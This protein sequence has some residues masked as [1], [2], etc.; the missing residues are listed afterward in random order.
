MKTKK[1]IKY[2]FFPSD[3]SKVIAELG[4]DV[5]VEQLKR[6][7]L[8]RNFEM[9]AEAAYLQ[10]KI[11]GFFH[12]YIG[13][14]A[15]QTSAVCAMSKEQ[16]WVTTYRCHALALLLDA[17]PNELLAELFG[18]ATGNAKGRGGSMHF[19]TERL[20]GG[21]G[22]VGGQIPIATGAAFTIN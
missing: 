18:R 4:R 3:A 21:F 7:L 22:I 17:T 10:G 20:L 13:Q 2:N 11:G 5:L 12:S 16:W 19:F 9:R 15:I 8:I 6:M 1:S 14:E